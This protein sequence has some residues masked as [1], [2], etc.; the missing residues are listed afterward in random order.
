MVDQGRPGTEPQEKIGQCL[1]LRRGAGHQ[2]P[3]VTASHGGEEFT[4]QYLQGVVVKS[5]K[6]K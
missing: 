5:E 6:E 2:W 3:H 4:A 1:V